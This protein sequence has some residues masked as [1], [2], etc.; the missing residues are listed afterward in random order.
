MSS[1]TIFYEA[2]CKD[3]KFMKYFKS[4]KKNGEVSKREFAK[5]VNEEYEKFSNDFES[6]IYI[7]GNYVFQK[8]N[9]QGTCIRID[10]L[11]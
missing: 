10:E 3:C 2:K 5:C 1:I 11:K 4:F 7:F 6:G 9:G 8:M